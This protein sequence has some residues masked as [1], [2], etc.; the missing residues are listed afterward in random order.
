MATSKI[1]R[2]VKTLKRKTLTFTGITGSEGANITLTST[3]AADVGVSSYNQIMAIGAAS[4]AGMSGAR[5]VVFSNGNQ[6]YIKPDKNVSNATLY[7]NV[8]YYPD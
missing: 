2:P 6:L 4:D 3:I 5:Y 8:S 1:N 7:V